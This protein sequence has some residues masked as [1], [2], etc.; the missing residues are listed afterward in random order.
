MYTVMLGLYQVEN[1]IKLPMISYWGRL[2]SGNDIELYS[3]CH[4]LLYQLSQESNIN[5][6]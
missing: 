6:S 2:I 4:R 1:H 5:S 3:V